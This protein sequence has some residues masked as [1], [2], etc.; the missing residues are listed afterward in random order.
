MLRRLRQRLEALRYDLY[1]RCVRRSAYFVA[2][3]PDQTTLLSS[4]VYS[5]LALKRVP[6]ESW[7]A[8]GLLYFGEILPR[9][10]IDAALG[11]RLVDGLLELGLLAETDPDLVCADSYQIVPLDGLYFIVGNRTAE[12]D[13]GSIYIG[14][15]SY[16]L[17]HCIPARI[18]GRVLDLCTGSGIQAI[19]AVARGGHGVAVELHPATFEAA[20]CNA[21]LNGLEERLEVRQGDLWAPVAG[22]TFDLVLSNPP[23]LGSPAAVPLPLYTWGGEDG[24]DVLRRILD[25]LPEHLTPQ[26]QAMM[27]SEVLGSARDTVLTP[28]LSGWLQEPHDLRAELVLTQREEV[29]REVIR[30]HWGE[31]LEGPEHGSTAELVEQRTDAVVS[32]FKERG[33]DHSYN[34][35][36][37]I[38]RGVRLGEE[39]LRV[40]R[41]FDP[42]EANS[43]PRLQ[44]G[45]Q[46]LEPRPNEFEL[47][48]QG[49]QERMAIPESLYFMLGRFDGERSVME[50]ALEYQSRYGAV[51]QDG[52]P[53][54]THVLDTCRTFV[55]VEA[56]ALPD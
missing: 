55:F 44:A 12:P 14:R 33:Y 42:V 38:D 4:H 22:E 3:L 39:R 24:L 21:V 48:L 20:R 7:A 10:Q 35:L 32:F 26:G 31:A 43:R 56:L 1:L 52:K 45:V 15:D 46:L 49:G 47:V 37:F 29:T 28:L 25:G 13:R 27:V 11:G 5:A 50:V 16:L 41:L 30:R 17:A 53:A 54:L 19:R 9:R 34:C 36:L 51:Q 6:A 8:L 18:E 2:P 23:F 40:T